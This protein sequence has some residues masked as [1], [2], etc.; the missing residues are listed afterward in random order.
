MGHT[1]GT[2]RQ[3]CENAARRFLQSVVVIDDQAELYPGEWVRRGLS[4]PAEASEPAR[5][6]VGRPL[7]G[8]S[9][10]QVARSGVPS[11]DGELASALADTREAPQSDETHILRAWLLTEKLAEEDI[12]C[13]IYRPTDQHTVRSSET[14]D[15]ASQSQP[16][17]TITAGMARL[18]DIVVLDWELG[19]D[20]GEGK[21]SQKARDIVKSILSHD[22][23]C[24]GRQ[25]LISIYTALPELEG[26]YSDVVEDVG[27]IEYIGGRL[28]QDRTDLSLSNSTTRIVCWNKSTKFTS[29]ESPTTVSESELPERL[30]SEFAKLYAGLLPS[31][32]LHSIASIRETT[33][34]L[35]STFSSEL[36][37]ALVSHR[38]FLPD[39]RDS[40][41]FVLDLV[42]GELRSA[43][44]LGRVGQEHAGEDAHKDWIAGQL[45]DREAF[46]LARYGCL[47][48]EEAFS[49]VSSGEKAFTTVC[50]TVMKRWVDE[51]WNSSKEFRH[52]KIPGKLSKRTV[53]ALVD[54]L[55]LAD[56]ERNLKVPQFGFD[57]LACF[58][59]EC[60]NGGK[61]IALNFARLTSL[62]REQHGT[63][64][65]P[66]GWY[67]RLSQGSM[68]REVAGDG[69]FSK[70]FLLCIQPRC[71][72]VRLK[73]GREF[74]FL[75]TTSKG[76]PARPKQCL[77][78]RC[79]PTSG[80][81]PQNIK[82][83]VYPFPYRQ[84]MLTFDP[85][86]S[87]SDHIQAVWEDEM[88]VFKH[89][90]K[91]YEWIADLK[92]L[93][94]QKLCDLVSTRQGSV[95]FQEYE[96]LRRKSNS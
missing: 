63:R 32:A 36:D 43:L 24:R 5:R 92:D 27:S 59:S 89:D 82:L 53:K 85:G 94:A 96:W 55:E 75:L 48:R 29:D 28:E 76:I 78:V 15:G 46:E 91:R 26:V 67:P 47:R 80:Q 17:V 93:L 71:D 4:A 95:G 38:S 35:L 11:D 50:K 1:V 77:I 20:S 7:A 65:L 73:D 62:K 45:N 61:T 3:R 56:L 39:P 10:D 22:H 34:H 21:G 25:R 66:D 31:I 58:F 23:D 88:W 8:L 6:L 37:P 51:K 2:Y 44:S 49:L 86:S 60:S 14:A 54:A 30:I 57:D 70:D 41:D 18:A 42:A 81:P 12:L 13:T 87:A 19:E 84:V 90:G 72:G 52:K 79:R 83:L 16:V 64:R 40:E 68:I 9:S 33:H 69:T 74:P